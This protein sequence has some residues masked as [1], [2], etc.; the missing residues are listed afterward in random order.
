LENAI[1]FS[2]LATI[3]NFSLK[4]FFIE[5]KEQ[6]TQ[7]F[8]KDII[9]QTLEFCF[10]MRMLKTRTSAFFLSHCH[11]IVQQK[12]QPPVNLSTNLSSTISTGSL[13]EGQKN[14]APPY[15][16]TTVQWKESR[17]PGL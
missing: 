14:L 12:F 3:N 13:A 15:D 9:I 6:K 4:P 11:I 16:Y 17:C 2:N 5:K 8:K 10:G 7:F 1:F